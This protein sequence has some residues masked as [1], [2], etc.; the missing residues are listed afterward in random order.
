M[1]RIPVHLFLSKRNQF[2]KKDRVEN[3]VGGLCVRPVKQTKQEHAQKRRE[4]PRCFMPKK[5]L[6]NRQGLTERAAGRRS[7]SPCV[8][9]PPPPP[10]PP[11][12]SPP[13]AS[14]ERETNG[15]DEQETVTAKTTSNVY[16]PPT[17]VNHTGKCRSGGQCHTSI[18]SLSA[19]LLFSFLRVFRRLSIKVSIHL[20]PALYA[21]SSVTLT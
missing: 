20:V 9:L 4:M 21:L 12:L 16:R 8:D 7:P 1:E 15:D 19:L 3:K 6:K 13:P 5:Q 17:P 11:L 10:P 14:L 18:V 2:E